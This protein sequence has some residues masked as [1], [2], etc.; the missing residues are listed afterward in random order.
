MARLNIATEALKAAQTWKERCLLQGG[1]IFTEKRLWTEENFQAL[2][3]HFVQNPDE[4]EG[5]FFSKLEHQL[6]LAPTSAKQL[7]A[8]ILWLMYLMVSTKSM[9]AATKKFQIK[10]VWDWSGE[11]FPDDH[12]AVG[13]LLGMGIA[14]PGTAFHTFRW[15]ECRFLIIAGCDWVTLPAQQQK[16]LLSDPWQFASWLEAREH[17]AGRQ[18][19]HVLLYLLYPDH[20]ERILSISHKRSIVRKMSS[21]LGLDSQIN[22][23]DL[24]S[25]DKAV[26][27]VREKLEDQNPDKEIDF[28][29]PKYKEQWFDAGKSGNGGG[30]GTDPDP[31][32]EAEIWFGKRFGNINAWLM[33]TGEGARLWPE[34]KEKRIIA[35][36]ADEVGDLNDYASKEAVKSALVEAYEHQNPI[37]DTLALWQ[38]ANEIQIG[39]LMIAKQGRSQLLGWGI[40]KSDYQYIPDR[41]EYQHIREVE[42]HPC[43]PVDLPNERRITPKTL[44]NFLK[45]KDWL[46][47]AFELMEQGTSPDPDPGPYTLDDALQDLFLTRPEFKEILDSISRWKNLILQGPPGVGKTF[48]AKRIAWSLIGHRISSPW[49]MVQFH[50]SYS[51]EDFI[52]GWRP[53]ETGGFELKEGVFHTF[54]ERA[55][56]N[57]GIP[58]VFIIDEIN[59]GNLSRIFGELLMLIEPDKRGP[60][61]AI[62]LTYSTP[63]ET[64]YVPTNVHILGMM[65]TADRSLAMVDYAL[66][67]RFAFHS[68]KPA[69]GNEEFQ[70][71]LLKADIDPN[72]V[73]LIDTR[74]QSINAEIRKDK[75]NLGPGFEIGHS[76]FVPSEEEENLDKEWYMR[77]IRAKIEPLLREY[78]FDHGDRVD[79]IIAGLLA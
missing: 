29:Q 3:R 43:D 60:K 22:Y 51:Y 77:V 12:W 37:M 2:N 65:N 17:S 74:M 72:L 14:H 58:H 48:I 26:L 47:F 33:G 41:A 40:V 25:V 45:F 23:K 5:T 66:R 59:R 36:G 44:T 75:K 11:A 38:F 56:K 67:R 50:Q 35:M 8:E 6:Q 54:C 19:R 70:D 55:K 7:A 18:L 15:R 71:F 46:H 1:S 53:T 39:D 69:Y 9:H 32:G 31:I 64:F 68:L 42:W 49:Q 4:G 57:A 78:W 10:Q 62:P 34:F 28:Y 63:G 79:T 52:H 61:Y 24:I 27:M 20:F 30:G 76:Y 73:K 16:D 13:E 21:E